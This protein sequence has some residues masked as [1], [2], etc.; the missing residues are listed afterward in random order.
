VLAPGWVRDVP[1]AVFG[2]MPKYL[3]ATARHAVRLR[4]DAARARRLDAEVL[5]FD[6]AWR[7]LAARADPAS[8]GVELE[9][10]R[11][12]IEEFRLSLHAQELRTLEPVSAKRLDAQLR[13]AQAEAAGG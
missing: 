11:W 3:R 5:P 8:P 7:E 2:Q 10:L 13:R 9:R 4:N 6:A 1:H 12:M